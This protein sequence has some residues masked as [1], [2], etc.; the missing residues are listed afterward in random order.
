[1]ETVYDFIFYFGRVMHFLRNPEHQEYVRTIV[2]DIEAN[3]LA[4]GDAELTDLWNTF[5]KY[6]IYEEFLHHQ[7]RTAEETATITALNTKRTDIL[8]YIFSTLQQIVKRSPH[9]QDVEWAKHLRYISKPY[10]KAPGKNLMSKSADIHGFVNVV[11][12]EPYATYANGLNLMRTFLILEKVN[13]ELESNYELRA[14][15]WLDKD[16]YG[17]LS[18]LRPKE[19]EAML[20]VADTLQFLHRANERGAKDETLRARL[21]SIFTVWNATP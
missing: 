15:L 1:M 18:Q 10:R 19:D 9:A 3:V 7:P 11:K 14:L 13:K 17:S 6:T 12:Q 5:K 21:E 20:N 16:K 2:E 4:I 8:L